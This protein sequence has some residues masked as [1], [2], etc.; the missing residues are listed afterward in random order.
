MLK[1]AAKTKKLG[2]GPTLELASSKWSDYGWETTVDV[3]AVPRSGVVNLGKTRV[4]T[5]GVTPSEQFGVD[6]FLWTRVSM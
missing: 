1:P 2:V 6:P 3:V 4:L 5:L